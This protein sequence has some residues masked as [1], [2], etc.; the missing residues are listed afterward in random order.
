M[1][2]PRLHRRSLVALPIRP[3]VEVLYSPQPA[4]CILFS[5]TARPLSDPA[6]RLVH[7]Q[8][9]DS[10]LLATRRALASGPCSSIVLGPGEFDSVYVGRRWLTFGSMHTV[11]ACRE[12]V[13]GRIR[14]RSRGWKAMCLL[15]SGMRWSVE[16]RSIGTVDWQSRRRVLLLC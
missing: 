13:R 10:A 16:R 8:R 5:T 4:P 3:C 14:S 1:A 11:E 15:Y 6:V 12:E 2:S 7:S 9:H